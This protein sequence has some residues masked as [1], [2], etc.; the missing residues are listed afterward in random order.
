MTYKVRPEDLIQI[1][2]L[3]NECYDLVKQFN[4]L[5]AKYQQE[6]PKSEPKPKNVPKEIPNNLL[7][8]YIELD[9]ISWELGQ[10]MKIEYIKDQYME[11]TLLDGNNDKTYDFLADKLNNKIYIVQEIYKSFKLVGLLCQNQIF[12]IRFNKNS[13]DGTKLQ[14]LLSKATLIASYP[15]LILDD[16]PSL[17]VKDLSNEITN[18]A[19][20]DLKFSP[21]SAR[22]YLSI[23]K[24]TEIPKKLG[25]FLF[26][27]ISTLLCN[28]LAVEKL[29]SHKRLPDLKISETDGFTVPPEYVEGV[30]IMSIKAKVP[31][32]SGFSINVQTN[33]GNTYEINY[34]HSK[35]PIVNDLLQDIK[36]ATIYVSC[37]YKTATLLDNS[38]NITV[39]KVV[40]NAFLDQL[41]ELNKRED[42]SVRARVNKDIKKFFG[43]NR[44]VAMKKK[45]ITID[46]QRQFVRTK[47]LPFAEFCNEPSGN[48][49]VPIII[50]LALDANYRVFAIRDS[51]SINKMSMQ[52]SQI[53]EQS[54]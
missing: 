21:L 27:I 9:K 45:T 51:H 37:Y 44:Q 36:D 18:F 10:T 54:D 5:V 42:I 35:D 41:V 2:T 40:H 43:Q 6:K 14:K 25:S 33:E 19:D 23:F 30:N 39:I 22:N 1:S 48:L 31:V 16:Y 28:K 15:N 32:N 49:T 20:V 34:L 52:G 47:D 24:I 4:V 38:K 3:I 13:F 11:A 7:F 12:I 50:S 46:P 17:Q 8:N 53:S 26:Q 29:N